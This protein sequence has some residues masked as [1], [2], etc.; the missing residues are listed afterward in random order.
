MTESGC[1]AVIVVSYVVTLLVM[2]LVATVR[3]IIADWLVVR[4]G[5][6][7]TNIYT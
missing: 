4:R 5:G 6:G 7:A 3:A 1:V 2:L